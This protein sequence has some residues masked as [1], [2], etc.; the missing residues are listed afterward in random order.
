MTKAKLI[1]IEKTKNDFSVSA[2][3]QRLGYKYKSYETEKEYKL[4]SK[5]IAP[6]YAGVGFYQKDAEKLFFH[7][8]IG[9]GVKN[10]SH[11]EMVSLIK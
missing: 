9:E 1:Q 4:Y 6:F 7:Q 10:Y 5:Q 2:I 8:W 11:I 3:M